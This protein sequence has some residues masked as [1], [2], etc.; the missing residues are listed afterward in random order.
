MS[1][2]SPVLRR[3]V[4]LA[5][6]ALLLVSAGCVTIGPQPAATGDGRAA[7]VTHV[8]DGDTVDVRFADGSTDTVRLLGVD[9]PE[10]H[11]Q[12]HPAEFEGVP[13]TDAGRRCLADAGTDATAFTARALSGGT[14]RIVVDETADRRDEYGRL[15]AYVVV[16]N[17]T[18]LNYRL[19]ATGNARVYDST[20]AQ[21][22]RFYAAEARAQARRLGLW[23][24]RAPGAVN[25]TSGVGSSS[26]VVASV[27]PDAA[28]NDVQN[29]G[30]EYVTFR[31]AG[32]DSLDLSGWTVRDEGGHV[33]PFPDGFELASG[34]S[35]RV[36]TGAGTDS[37]DALYWNADG[38]VWNNDGDAVVVT[39]A[40]GVVVLRHRY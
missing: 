26:L 12:N 37:A 1:R 16:A 33:Y 21:S 4:L 39:N 32:N 19:V 2:R 9:S 27:H 10:T 38:A 7:T 3:S 18:N 8:V 25:A 20:F 30:D 23:E 36:Y 28:G 34:A 6:L 35:V 24:C 22:D 40:T 29:L 31:N 5:V 11:G 13:D 15:L 14:A 17:G